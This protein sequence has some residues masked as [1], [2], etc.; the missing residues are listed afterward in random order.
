MKSKSEIKSKLRSKYRAMRN[1]MPR[2]YKA[3]LDK[4]ICVNLLSL[5]EYEESDLI[6]VYSPCNGEIDLTCFFNN[7]ISNKKRLAFPRCVGNDMFFSICMPHQLQPGMYNI[8]EP[9][10]TF[11]IIRKFP[12]NTL[13]VLPCLAVS[14]DGYRI[15]YGRGYY[16]RFL[17]ENNVFSVAAVY[18]HFLTCENFADEFD[19][20][21]NIILTEKEIIKI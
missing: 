8:P 16:D 2:D 6:L 20:K 18:S 15:G 10:V 21:A 17:A 19:K 1:E 5:R 7:S 14:A 3:E 11:E 9:P 13:C 12:A 4:K